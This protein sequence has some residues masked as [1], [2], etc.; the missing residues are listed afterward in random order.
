M[1][2]LHVSKS[3]T[4]SGMENVAL[5]MI[6]AMPEEVECVYLT[7]TGPIET[8]LLEYNIEYIGVEKVDEN[9]SSSVNLVQDINMLS[10]LVTKDVLND[11]KS[12]LLKY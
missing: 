1:T 11:L 3:S 4:Y 8:K 9:I 12:K 10:I 2:V 5:N 6:K 7:A